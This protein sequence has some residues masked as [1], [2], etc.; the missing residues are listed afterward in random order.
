MQIPSLTIHCL[1]KMSQIVKG[2]IPL[3]KFFSDITST[4]GCMHGAIKFRVY[5]YKKPSSIFVS[6]INN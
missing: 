2:R 6:S 4:D 1:K 3:I 5:I